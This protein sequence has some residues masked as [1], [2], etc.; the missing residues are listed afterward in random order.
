VKYPGNICG[1]QLDKYGR[2]SNAKNHKVLDNTNKGKGIG[3]ND[4]TEEAHGKVAKG[5]WSRK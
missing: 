4:D 2:C 1:Q 3:K 5:S